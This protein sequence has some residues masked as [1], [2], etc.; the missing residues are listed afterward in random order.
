MKVIHYCL[1]CARNYKRSTF[2]VIEG[3]NQ[4]IKDHQLDDQIEL[5]QTGCLDVCANAVTM[6]R[7]DGEI[8]VVTKENLK[9][10]FDQD[11]KEFLK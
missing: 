9:F 8:L 3:L 10:T 4:L 1:G 5:I 11:I 2:D 7:W 6:R